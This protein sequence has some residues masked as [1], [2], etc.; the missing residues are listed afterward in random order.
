MYRGAK[1][2]GQEREE[3]FFSEGRA[4]LVLP[5]LRLCPTSPPLTYQ[6]WMAR[7]DWLTNNEASP[8]IMLQDTE[9]D[10]FISG[11]PQEASVCLTVR[12]SRCCWWLLW[13]ARAEVQG[14]AWPRGLGRRKA[15][16]GPQ[17]HL[18]WGWGKGQEQ[19]R[20]NGIWG[21]D[22]QQ[23]HFPLSSF[24]LHTRPCSYFPH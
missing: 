4:V 10:D 9:K 12:D 22:C 13:G 20:G 7:K 15:S 23:N 3:I 8:L 6:G 19:K 24:R 17:I 21:L 11:Q 2:C 5:A 16:S 1:C 18:W 14:A